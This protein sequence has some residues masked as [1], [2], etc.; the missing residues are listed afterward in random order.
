[1]KLGFTTL[2]CPDWTVQEIATRAAELGYDGVELRTHEDGNH[3]SPDANAARAAEVKRIFEDAGSRVF[4]LMAYPRFAVSDAAKRQESVDL[5]RRVIDLAV[6]VGAGHVRVFGG[7]LEEG[8]DRSEVLKTVAETIRPVC[9]HADE[10]GIGLA[11]ETHD[12]WCSGE[13]IKT[14]VEA[15]GSSALGVVWDFANVVTGG[16]G[17]LD[18]SYAAL[19]KYVKYCHTKDAVKAEDGKWTYCIPGDGEIGVA[20]AVELLRGGGFDGFLSFEWEKK[21]HPELA[22]PEEAFPAYVKNMK[23]ILGG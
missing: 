16:A 13:V 6:G 7:T 3:L 15:T 20:H 12:D 17:T 14:L 19:G 5:T 1:M 21:W 23:G 22:P 4:S 18:D 8:A 2:G 9:K 11:I 10:S